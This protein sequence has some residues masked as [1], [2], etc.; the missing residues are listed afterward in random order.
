MF[1]KALIQN[2]KCFEFESVPKELN[3]AQAFQA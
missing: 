2:L 3:T 1:Q